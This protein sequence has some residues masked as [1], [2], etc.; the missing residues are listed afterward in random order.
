SKPVRPGVIRATIICILHF[1]H[2][3]RSS[4]IA[5]APLVLSESTAARLFP[6]PNAPTRP[7]KS[8]IPARQSA[9]LPTLTKTF[10]GGPVQRCGPLGGATHVRRSSRQMAG[11]P[12]VSR[13]ATAD[14][15]TVDEMSEHTIKIRLG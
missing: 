10:V 15:G 1:G 8:H 5:R 4:S 2:R 9:R 7:L 13:I 6:L 14:R 12:A 11:R 3:G